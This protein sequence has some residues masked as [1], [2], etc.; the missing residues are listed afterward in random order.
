MGH[1]ACSTQVEEDKQFATDLI[2]K[3]KACLKWNVSKELLEQAVDF[4][5]EEEEFTEEEEDFPEKD[6]WEVLEKLQFKNDT[7]EL[8]ILQ[9]SDYKYK[10]SAEAN[11][12]TKCEFTVSGGYPKNF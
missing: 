7:V 2:S 4:T 10:V 12:G 3:A 5:E 8:E 1:V 9:N 6:M 11:D